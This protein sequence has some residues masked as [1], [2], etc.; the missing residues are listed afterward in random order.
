[1][2]TQLLSYRLKSARRKRRLVKKDRDK[3]LLRMQKEYDGLKA[4][5][6][7]LPYVPLDEP[8]QR[9]W[10]RLWVLRPEAAKSDKADLYQG[11]LDKLTEVQYHYDQSFKQ[12]KRRGAWHRYYFDKLP[13]LY[14][15]GEYYWNNNWHKFTEDQ[16]AYFKPNKYWDDE[17]CRWKTCY[18]FA[19]TELIMIAVVPLIVDKVQLHDNELEQQLAFI[20]DKLYKMPHPARLTKISGGYYKNWYSKSFPEK[21]KY[22]NPLK[23]KPKW[24]WDEED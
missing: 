20:D 21:K 22:R 12:P 15:I 1:M 17:K 4:T 5:R 11:I 23:N 19:F 3:Q 7:A 13:K 16:R 24:C 6:S 2:D 9:G 18:E 14:G 8:Y 10:K